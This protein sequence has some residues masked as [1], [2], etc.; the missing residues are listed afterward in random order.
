MAGR[1]MSGL[2]LF[3][4]GFGFLADVHHLGAAGAEIAALRRL[5]RRGHIA[6]Q[7]NPVGA[8]FQ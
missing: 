8:A 7:D 5:G 4:F 1:E 3:E 6:L 2:Y